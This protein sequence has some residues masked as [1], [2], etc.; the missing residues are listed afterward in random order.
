MMFN[1]F[2]DQ[3]KTNTI[4]YVAQ[5]FLPRDKEYS[6]DSSITVVHLR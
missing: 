3:Y 4:V 5:V 1:C 2:I 6:C